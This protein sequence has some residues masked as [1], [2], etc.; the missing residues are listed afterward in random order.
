MVGVH[1]HILKDIGYG[2]LCFHAGGRIK[3]SSSIKV[4]IPFPSKPFQ[5]SGKITWCRKGDHGQYLVGISFDHMVEEP[6][7]KRIQLI[8][9]LKK[10]ALRKHVPFTG[11]ELLKKT[12]ALH[13]V[14]KSTTSTP[15]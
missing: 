11:E 2:G 14:A 3:S 4:R 6:V 10:R 13:P 1:H 7:I 9:R 12:D 5:V 15:T 8:E